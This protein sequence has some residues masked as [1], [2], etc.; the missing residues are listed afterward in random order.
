MKR[1]LIGAVLALLAWAA[2]MLALPFVGP[3]GRQVAVVVQAG[4][5]DGAQPDVRERTR[6]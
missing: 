2:I 1:T 5:A 3:S 6:R 4:F